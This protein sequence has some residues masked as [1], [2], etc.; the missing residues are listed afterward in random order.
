MTGKVTGNKVLWVSCVGLLMGALALMWAPAVSG[1]STI[2]TQIA[3]QDQPAKIDRSLPGMKKGIVSKA[4]DRTVWIDGARYDLAPGAL[5]ED[6][7]GTPLNSAVY[8][9]S[10]VEWEVQYW[11]V[12]DQTHQINQMIISF[13]E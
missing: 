5:V 3:Q 11:L 10:G 2:P 6:K 12:P 4:H 9:A 8:Q 7:F 1:E 13:P